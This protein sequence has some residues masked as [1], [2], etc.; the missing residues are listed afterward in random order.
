V[1]SLG[2]AVEVALLVD[3]DELA[4]MSELHGEARFD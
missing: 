2:G 4:E 1:Q 3:G